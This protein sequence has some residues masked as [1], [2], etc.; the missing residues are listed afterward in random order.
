M[1]DNESLNRVFPPHALEQ[2]QAD[3]GQA[4]IT[5]E[6]CMGDQKSAD[7]RGENPRSSH[8]QKYPGRADMLCP[9]T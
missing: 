1:P 2:G 5:A 3:R 8:V 4:S 7:D 9:A 6:A